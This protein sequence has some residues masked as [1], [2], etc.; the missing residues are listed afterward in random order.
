MKV[1]RGFSATRGGKHEI[2]KIL[3]FP[4]GFVLA[5]SDHRLKFL[6]P[7]GLVI[8]QERVRFG[9]KEPVRSDI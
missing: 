9:C 6:G 7:V 2:L 8:Q 3:L 5:I 4:A 1:L